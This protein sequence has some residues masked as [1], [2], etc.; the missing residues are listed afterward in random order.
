MSNVNW[1]NISSFSSQADIFSWNNNSN[2]TF[3]DFSAFSNINSN[4][5]TFGNSFFPM[6]FNSTFYPTSNSWQNM[7]SQ[8]GNIDFSFS[9]NYTQPSFDMYSSTRTTSE[10]KTD[11]DDKHP[12]YNSSKDINADQNLRYLKN[13][14]SEMQDKTKGLIAYA[15]EKGYDVEIS[16]GYRTESEQ[17]ALRE[18]YQDE[19]G[20]VATNSAHCAGKAIDIRVTKNGKDSDAGYNLLG[21]YAKSEL[22]MRWGGD[23]TSYRERWHFDYDWA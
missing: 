2:S 5:S 18:R 13:L 22:G 17:Q 12:K 23:F 3:T 9:F 21:E 11:K 19:P 10:T 14:T 1:N 7:S 6:P 8:V 20:R 4:Q 16:S 15:N